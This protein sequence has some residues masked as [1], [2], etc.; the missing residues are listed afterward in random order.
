MSQDDDE[1]YHVPPQ[2]QRIFGAGIKRKRVPFVAASSLTNVTSEATP[3]SG[4][5]TVESRYLSIVLPQNE[6]RG[7][8]KSFPVQGL[9]NAV[10]SVCSLP[11]A[12]S[13]ITPHET[14]LAH[15]ACLPHSHPPS[16]LDR[17]HVGLRYLSSYGWDPD[18]RTGLGSKGEGIRVPLKGK[19]KNN[20]VGLGVPIS[21]KGATVKKIEKEQKLNAKQ[22]RQ[23]ESM[24][25]R[26]A[27]KLRQMFYSNPDVDRYLGP[28]G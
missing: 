17:E 28:G 9:D 26:K 20:T 14:S 15:Q 22:V 16:H 18:S 27:D 6:E 4:Q 2:D 1:N 7:A 10:C 12:T 21:T 13:P 3:I 19:V 25:K 11:L 5:P 24:E 23:H 8:S